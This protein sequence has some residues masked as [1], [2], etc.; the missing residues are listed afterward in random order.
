MNSKEIKK[1]RS[2]GEIKK[3]LNRGEII[4]QGLKTW[5]KYKVKTVNTDK[6]KWSGGSMYW[7]EEKPKTVGSFAGNA[8]ETSNGFRFV[9]E[10]KT[11]TWNRKFHRNLGGGAYWDGYLQRVYIYI[12]NADLV[13]TGFCKKERFG[14]DYYWFEDYYYKI[15]ETKQV[16]GD[17]IEDIEAEENTYPQN[18]IQDG[19]WYVLKEGE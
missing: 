5:K 16:Q 2:N 1:I 3:V 8:E 17:Y 11:F 14:R 9:W 10:G 19:F 12:T 4:W 18:G 6:Y 13:A 15:Y 7:S